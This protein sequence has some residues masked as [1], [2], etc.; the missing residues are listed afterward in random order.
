MDKRDFD[1]LRSRCA[2]RRAETERVG[3]LIYEAIVH[4]DDEAAI[5]AL[6]ALAYKVL[7]PRK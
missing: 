4:T 1:D 3:D 6:V 7:E 5:N 2:A